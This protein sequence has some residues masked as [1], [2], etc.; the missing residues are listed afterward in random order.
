MGFLQR[1]ILCRMEISRLELGGISYPERGVSPHNGGS[2]SSRTGEFL[3]LRSEFGLF[4]LHYVFGIRK[5]DL[6]ACSRNA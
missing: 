3:K 4:T 2:L 6:N 1:R 5:T